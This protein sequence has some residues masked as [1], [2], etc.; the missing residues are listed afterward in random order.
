[1]ANGKSITLDGLELQVVD[2][3][4]SKGFAL[5]RADVAIGTRIDGEF[6]GIFV[7]P[8]IQLAKKK[9]GSGYYYLPPFEYVIDKDT[10]E[11]VIGEDGY[12]KKREF[13]NLFMAIGGNKNNPQ[14]KGIVS[15]AYEGRKALIGLLV[16][17]FE[18]LGSGA[19]ADSNSGR[20]ASRAPARGQAPA[21]PAAVAQAPANANTAV[22]DEGFAGEE[23]DDLPF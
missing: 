16:E 1:M 9:D 8:G 2:A 19:T 23:D 20:G 12:P 10:G 18:N 15:E 5:M 22:E 7:V 21:R 14:N 3:R 17:A 6:K 13:F 4:A 11:R